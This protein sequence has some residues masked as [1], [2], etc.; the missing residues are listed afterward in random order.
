MGERIVLDT[1]NGGSG[2]L[3]C[4]VVRVGVAEVVR[5]VRDAAELRRRIITTQVAADRDRRHIVALR[6]LGQRRGHVLLARGRRQRKRERVARVERPAANGLVDAEI[7]ERIIDGRVIKDRFVA[8]VGHHGAQIAV[9]LV[10]GHNGHANLMLVVCNA[11]DYL[12]RS[13]CLGVCRNDFGNRVLVRARGMQLQ[14]GE[15]HRAVC[16]IRRSGAHVTLQVLDREGV[17]ACRS[18]VEA[19][20][21]DHL[22]GMEHDFAVRLIR[23]FE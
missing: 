6:V 19:L 10:G 20:S 18:G 1:V 9:E 2:A 15:R 4:H 22:L 21:V 11:V 13:Q 7:E 3:L 14:R 5:R 23:V 12:V 17:P 16:R 8:L